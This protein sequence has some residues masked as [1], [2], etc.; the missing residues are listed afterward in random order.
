MARNLTGGEISTTSQLLL[1]TGNMKLTQLQ[2]F[3]LLHTIQLEEVEELETL[4]VLEEITLVAQGL[5][6]I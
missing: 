2:T 6:M 5:E 1:L 4:D 3:L